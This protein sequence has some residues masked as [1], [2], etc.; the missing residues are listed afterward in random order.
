MF[1][2]G[3]SERG[4]LTVDGITDKLQR[5]HIERAALAKQFGCPTFTRPG[6][7]G[8]RGMWSCG[9]DPGPMSGPQAH[10]A[11]QVHIDCVLYACAVRRR[12]RATL[13]ESGAMRLDGRE[14]R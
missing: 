1:G 7:R 8:E 2:S 14:D 3:Y 12:A 13:V 6:H 10:L 5:D 9:S 4:I 11:M